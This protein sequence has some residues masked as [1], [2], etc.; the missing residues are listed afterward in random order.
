MKKNYGFFG[1]IASRSSGSSASFFCSDIPM[2]DTTRAVIIIPPSR[3]AVVAV[4]GNAMVSIRKTGTSPIAIIFICISFIFI[5][6]SLPS[7]RPVNTSS[8]FVLEPHMRFESDELLKKV[9]GNNGV[10]TRKSKSASRLI[11]VFRRL[12]CKATRLSIEQRG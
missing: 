10:N 7:L 8:L 12:T 6:D 3:I 11:L 9:I 2:K 4:F 1:G 5:V